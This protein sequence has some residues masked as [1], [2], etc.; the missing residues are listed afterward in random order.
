MAQVGESSMTL[1][2]GQLKVII[3]TNATDTVKTESTVILNS[4]P[5]LS[6]SLH[7]AALTLKIALPLKRCIKLLNDQFDIKRWSLSTD[8]SRAKH[9]LQGHF[10]VTMTR[11]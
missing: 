5:N 8:W 3:S 1:F 6:N 4:C 2:P 9:L 11:I 7:N 10:W